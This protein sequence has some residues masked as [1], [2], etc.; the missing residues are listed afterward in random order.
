MKQVTYKITVKTRSREEIV[1]ITA[2]VKNK[3]KVAGIKQGLCVVFALHT[4]CCI[5]INENADDNVKADLISHM[6]RVFPL[7]ERYSHLEG[8]SDS[9]LKTSVFG[10]SEI[11]IIENGRLLL[12][13]WQGIMLAEFDGPRSRTVAIYFQGE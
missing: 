2:S 1:D 8:N 13:T 5:T 6:A 9:H 4:T 7:N 10:P 11:I 3:L 12:G